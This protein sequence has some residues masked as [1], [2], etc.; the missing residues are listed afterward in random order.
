[1]SGMFT[2]LSVYLWFGATVLFCVLSAIFY[3]KKHGKLFQEVA[4]LSFGLG[5]I[6]FLFS[7]LFVRTT[8]WI[9]AAY[10]FVFGI[11]IFARNRYS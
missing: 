5:I 6:F 8:L 10:L 3:N 11:F 4:A 9:F 1:M 2:K 7:G